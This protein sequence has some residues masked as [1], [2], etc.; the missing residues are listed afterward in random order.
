MSL[1]YIWNKPDYIE[2][3]GNIYPITMDKYETFQEVSNPLY[4]SRQH[5]GENEYKLL[6]LVLFY[7]YYDH[8]DNE[9]TREEYIKKMIKDMEKLFS[10]ILKTDVYFIQLEYGDYFFYA[11]ENQKITRDNYDFV[12]KTIMKQNLMFEQK[13]FKNE[14][15]REWAEMILKERA[16]KSLK[17]TMED[18]ISTISTKTGKHYWDLE[19]YSIYQ[20][21]SDFYRIFK[22]KD[23]DTC[24]AYRCAGD[25]KIKIEHFAESLDLYKNPYDDLFVSNDKLKNLDKAM[26]S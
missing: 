14:T 15:V 22:D 17:I 11:N 25:D 24:I 23:Y 12:R 1:G 4:I 13:I 9:Y 20:I 10:L 5:F 19:K 6:D 21:Y 18:M 2:G 16:K 26:K 7:S 8:E 3:V